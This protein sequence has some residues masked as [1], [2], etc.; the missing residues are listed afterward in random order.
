MRLFKEIKKDMEYP[1]P[2]VKIR[3]MNEVARYLRDAC[4]CGMYSEVLDKLTSSK[5][6]FGMDAN[7]LMA[8]LS[9]RYKC[10]E[11]CDKVKSI[12]RT[13]EEKR[14][15][16]IEGDFR[17][18]VDEKYQFAI[19][20][21]YGKKVDFEH[22]TCENIDDFVKDI[23]VKK[24]PGAL[25][26][27]MWYTHFD[28]EKVFL[29]IYTQYVLPAFIDLSESGDMDKYEI[30]SSIMSGYIDELL[31]YVQGMG[32]VFITSLP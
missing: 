21:I 15:V 24:I 28:N 3:C 16:P 8:L 14:G 27:F 2:E 23:E 22:L 20:H 9:E 13:F 7:E 17:V 19:G 1:S 11:I 12:K 18:S 25:Y 30:L 10:N 26:P 32:E 4:D 29:Y 5:Y 6:R 31:T